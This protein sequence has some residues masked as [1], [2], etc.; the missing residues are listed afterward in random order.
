MP[1]RELTATEKDIHFKNNEQM[2][3]EDHK[4][5]L[6]GIMDE[7]LQHGVNSPHPFQ[8]K[9]D[10]VHH[11]VGGAQVTMSMPTDEPNH[12][13]LLDRIAAS[14]Q[15]LDESHLKKLES[16]RDQHQYGGPVLSYPSGRAEGSYAPKTPQD[17][18]QRLDSIINNHPLRQDAHIHSLI[19]KANSDPIGVGR[20]SP[21]G[22]ALTNNGALVVHAISHLKDYKPEHIEK[23]V[24]NS[25]GDQD[26]RIKQ[27]LLTSGRLSDQQTG[28]VIDS[29]D[30]NDMGAALAVIKQDANK[31][32]DPAHMKR[33][34]QNPH[35]PV[36]AYR[37]IPA[38][39]MDEKSLHNYVDRAENAGDVE[40]IASRH[41]FN[42]GHIKA[43]LKKRRLGSDSLAPLMSHPHFNSEDIENVL[44]EPSF[45]QSSHSANKAMISSL[46][47]N[48]NFN[49]NHF[50][51]ILGD[52][53]EGGESGN[54]AEALASVSNL[55]P[56][57]IDKI[58][59]AHISPDRVARESTY[60]AI[61]QRKDLTVGHVGKLLD[62][63]PINGGSQHY[64]SLAANTDAPLF[65]Q[66]I[67]KLIQHPNPVT[68]ENLAD[69]RPD[70][71]RDKSHVDAV[72]AM[73]PD[74]LKKLLAI[75]NNGDIVSDQHLK[76]ALDKNPE[77]KSREGHAITKEA[78]ARG[79]FR[80]PEVSFPMG[81]GKLREVRHL[82]E[83]A[84]GT[85]HKKDLE[86]AGLK[87]QDLKIQH[88][89]DAKGNITADK[90]QQHIDSLPKMTYGH[91][92]T[93]YG[94]DRHDDF[95][96]EDDAWDKH[97]DAFRP[98]DY[99]V[100]E[101]DPEY[102]DE[103]A[104][105][106]DHEDKF[107]PRDHGIDLKDYEYQADKDETPFHYTLY[108]KISGD[109]M[110]VGS[111]KT[112][113]EAQD[114]IKS[115]PEY[116]G[117]ISTG[118][119][120]NEQNAHSFVANHHA[121]AHIHKETGESLRD[122]LSEA[123]DKHMDDFN[124]RNYAGDEDF[125]DQHKW[126][127]AMDQA[128][129]S[130]NE[131]F[132]RSQYGKSEEEAYAEAQDVNSQQ[133]NLDESKVF[134]MNLTPEHIKELK[135]QGVWDTYQKML[136][137]THDVT[138]RGNGIGWVR[139]TDTPEGDTHID[140]IQTD[141]GQSVA[142][143]VAEQ[144]QR[145][146][147]RGQ[148]TPEQAQAEVERHKRDFPEDHYAKI[149]KIVFGDQHPGDIIHEAFLQHLR[150]KGQIGKKVSLWQVRPKSKLSGQRQD[151]ELPVHM[152]RTYQQQ[153]PK[154]GYKPGHYGQDIPDT[155]TNPNFHNSPTW[156]QTL[157]KMEEIR[158]KLDLLKSKVESR[159]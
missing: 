90:V 142:K 16:L 104:A 86:K 131:N 47:Q 139:Y 145:A 154:M 3:P 18:S 68:V 50:N 146:V 38:E 94:E 41:V 4:A 91:S 97:N 7:T 57:H 118:S 19:D 31:E 95:I 84:G 32:L 35:L 9:E 37:S 87:P 74:H 116:R 11:N 54:H 124:V 89:M 48:P 98:E 93:T 1:R 159:K 153:P 64:T 82:A 55:K 62:S 112:K 101:N 13:Y 36:E 44:K 128:S 2:S 22:K 46:Y 45:W 85:I 24:Q 78:K 109:P 76:D 73:G 134:Q 105:R 88:L 130:H 150:D 100:D 102:V 17:F 140:E 99:G 133:H 83:Q 12:R 5:A 155:Q 136:E 66:H 111:A 119:R 143:R 103:D 49:E 92:H 149:N 63:R 81:A 79:I 115:R 132:D 135:K 148:L 14:H 156:L 61:A 144:A 75:D 28:H 20:I 151:E 33:L 108:N 8:R 125:R 126:D 43:L 56:E 80:G 127:R 138:A 157:K 27:I 29:L 26:S 71:F 147:E 52:K 6:H 123:M 58:L 137:K 122:H 77:L 129:E 152:Q 67:Q 15:H 42:R 59:D 10:P 121:D 25:H 158:N 40:D 72:A 117:E 70:L 120:I 106:Q 113:K 51:N 110:V 21:E 141:L 69:A 39:Y 34:A 114:K 107:R 60:N 23:L 65:N 53:Y 96:S 30:R